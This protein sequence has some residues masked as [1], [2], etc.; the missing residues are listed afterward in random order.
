MA[1]TPRTYLRRCRRTYRRRRRVAKTSSRPRP[2][3][4]GHG[5]DPL[6]PRRAFLGDDLGPYVGDDA[7]DADVGAAQGVVDVRGDLGLGVADDG[8]RVHPH[9]DLVER[10]GEIA[11][12]PDVRLDL[13]RGLDCI[14]HALASVSS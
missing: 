9:P 8:L 10:L 3:H 14:R 7:V 5:H 4:Q 12:A 13:R 6:E 1:L 2:P 11:P